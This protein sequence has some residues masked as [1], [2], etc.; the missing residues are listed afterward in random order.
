MGFESIYVVGSGR[1]AQ[2][3]LS[4]PGVPSGLHVVRWGR[5]AP[6]SSRPAIVLHAG[7]GREM[8]ECLDFC[9]RTRS[10]FVQLSTGLEAPSSSPG[11]PVVVCPNTSIL[12][13]KLLS[14]L[15]AHPGFFL[16]HQI[17]LTESH[18][19]TKTS[20]PGTAFAFADFLGM[21]REEIRSIRDPKIQKDEIGIP[22]EHLP[23][24][25]WHRITIRDASTE[26]SL[27]TKVLGL[28][29]YAEGA[30]EIVRAARDARLEERTYSVLEVLEA[31]WAGRR[32][33][34]RSGA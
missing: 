24:H 9:A 16:D 34:V 12:V 11:H 23:A 22:A 26:I 25:A 17:S 10:V 7:S 4:H 13:L 19:A 3:I 14:L 20:E 27:E 33:D 21:A 5:S 15:G 18:Q 8:A 31:S 6:D 2:A 28:A 32:P 30:W 1:L 29:S